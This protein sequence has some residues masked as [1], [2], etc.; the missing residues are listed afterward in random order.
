VLALSVAPAAKF[1]DVPPGHWAEEAVYQLAD[2]GIIL[3]FPDGTYRGNEFL[4]RYQAALLIYRLLERLRAEFQAGA[5]EETLAALRNAVQ[6]LAAELASLGVRVSA[7]ED[8]A[9]T[10]ADVARLQA[11]ID[12]LKKMKPAGMD[13]AALKELEAKVEAAAVA[14]DTAAAKAEAAAAKAEEAMAAAD[15]AKGLAEANADSIKALNELAVMLNQDVLGLQD[16]VAALEK[17]L[18]A[19]KGAQPKGVA[20]ASDLQALTEY[21]Q[22]LSGDVAGLA[23]KVAGLED[24]VG[25]LERNAF[26]ISGSLTLE[27]KAI[28]ASGFAGYDIDRFIEDSAFSAGDTD[29]PKDGQVVDNA[30]WLTSIPG[31]T[32]ANL[33]VKF[34]TGKLAGTSKGDGVNTYEELFQFSL[35]GS[36]TKPPSPPVITGPSLQVDAVKTTLPV[37]EGQQLSLVFGQTT[38]AKFTEYLFDNDKNPYG[39]GLVATLTGLPAGAELTFAY[40]N[41]GLPG[42]DYFYAGRL[43]LSPMEGFGLGGSYIAQDSYANPVWGI[44]A[45]L[46]LGPLGLEGEYFSDAAGATSYYAIAKAGLGPIELEASYRNIALITGATTANGD[47]ATSNAH[48]AAPFAANQNGFGIA[49]STGFG[50]LGLKGQ[51]QSYTIAGTPTTYWEV[52]AD[53]G[54]AGKDADGNRIATGLA[55]FHARVTYSQE[56]PFPGA[57]SWKPGAGTDWAPGSVNTGILAQ[58]HHWGDAPDAAVKDLNL[59]FEYGTQDYDRLNVYADYTAKFGPLS[60]FALGGYYSAPVAGDSATKFGFKVETDPFALPLKPSL[61]GGYVTRSGA[62]GYAGTETKWFAG[63]EFAEFLFAPHSTFK[64]QYGSYSSAGLSLTPAAADADKAWNAG[65]YWLYTTAPGAGGTLTGFELSWTY[66]DLTASFGSYVDNA[67][68][69]ADAFRIRYEVEF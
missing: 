10:Q 18:V 17:E 1:S 11:A 25:T 30:E 3:G 29:S 65:T 5:D 22:A 59:T 33:N 36:W 54:K 69:Y 68:N 67:G 31:Q 26:T 38:K 8:N 23:G 14:A 6:E 61:M 41:N 58:L 46:E 64:A 51:Y 60:V 55:G 13:M 2:E 53:L 34:Q 52:V 37:A 40:G 62:N 42:Y 45:S 56:S 35:S 21:V 19:V 16:R 28:D 49:A 32:T 39:P 9:A 44:D 43:A 15:A 57:Q 48:N 63:I 47:V 24:R 27:Y 4:T 50:L 7:L 20:K 12:E 66:W